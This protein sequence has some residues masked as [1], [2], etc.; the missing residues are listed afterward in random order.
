M[1]P[2]QCTRYCEHS[3]GLGF[4]RGVGLMANMKL[5]PERKRPDLVPVTRIHLGRT[6]ANG[7]YNHICFDIN[8][9]NAAGDTFPVAGGGSTDRALRRVGKR[10]G[11]SCFHRKYRP[12][13][14]KFNY[15]YDQAVGS[16]N[17]KIN[18]YNVW[19][20]CKV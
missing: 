13:M 15:P 5:A 1:P 4:K 19:T 17:I 10:D 14:P 9:S 20:Y 6:A 2:R 12:T 11:D 7:Y 16:L 8:A 3:K 18:V